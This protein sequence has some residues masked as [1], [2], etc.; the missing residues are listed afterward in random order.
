M[1]A[2]TLFDLFDM[3]CSL[4]SS[5]AGFSHITRSHHQD[6]VRMSYRNFLSFLCYRTDEGHHQSHS[7]P[8]WGLIVFLSLTP[9]IYILAKKIIKHPIWIGLVLHGAG[10]VMKLLPEYLWD[11][12]P[13][14]SCESVFVWIVHVH[15]WQHYA[16]FYLHKMSSRNNPR[17]N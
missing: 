4:N 12:S 7:W 15:I 10:G 6:T 14:L 5:H 8:C 13:N 2:L 1:E 16:L 9:Y 3:P 11:F 17:L